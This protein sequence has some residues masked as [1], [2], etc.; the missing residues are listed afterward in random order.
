MGVIDTVMVGQLGLPALGAVGL[1]HLVSFTALSFFWGTLSGVNTLV[2]QAVGA[3]DREA[4][5]RVFWQ[6]IYFALFS[7]VLIASLWPLTPLVFQWT[8]GSPEVQAIAA[9]YMR[10]RLL[11][12]GGVI[13][14]WAC[15]NFYRGIGRTTVTMWCGIGQ[16]VL[17]CLLNYLLI[18]G[19]LGAP[20][21]GAA[22][23][24]LGT[25]LAKGI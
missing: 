11:G 8:G 7:S 19:K 17:N 9:D 5:G 14:L 15:D 21:M 23:A 13:L 4:A 16:M 22:G 12:G 18:F 1:G 3:S 2:A 24:A 10:I 20:R 6:G 25:V